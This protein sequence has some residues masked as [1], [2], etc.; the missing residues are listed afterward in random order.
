LPDGLFSDYKLEFEELFEKN[1]SGL[2]P[3]STTSEFTPT[4]PALYGI[5]RL[6]T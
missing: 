3:N 6:P 1:Y 2:V 5:G 4:T